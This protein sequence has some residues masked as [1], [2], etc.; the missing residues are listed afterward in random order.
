MIVKPYPNINASA[1]TV[2]ATATSLYDLLKTAASV[3]TDIVA[4]NEKDCDALDIFVG[5]A[6]VVATWDGTTPTNTLGQILKSAKNSSFRGRPLSK[7]KLIRTGGANV[8]CNVVYGYSCG[9]E[10]EVVNN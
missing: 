3:S 10:S 8:T 1:I 7:M 2:T 9:N 6:D 5:A 4:P